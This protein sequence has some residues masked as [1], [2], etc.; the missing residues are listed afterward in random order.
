MSE[1]DG[2][3]E[4]LRQIAEGP[5]VEPA[6][7][8]DTLKGLMNLHFRQAKELYLEKGVQDMMPI[9]LI[10]CQNNE[11]LPILTPFNDVKTKNSTALLIRAILQITKAKRYAF[12]SEAWV[13][14]MQGA[15]AR[16][17]EKGKPMLA[18]SEYEDKQEVVHITGEDNEGHSAFEAWEIVRDWETGKVVDLKPHSAFSEGQLSGRFM[19]LFE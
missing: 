7:G 12:L 3:L 2:M 4:S 13:K 11:I 10:V 1:I 9:W 15:E 8:S 19:N 17:Y 5:L 18:P 6:E 16:D 14:T